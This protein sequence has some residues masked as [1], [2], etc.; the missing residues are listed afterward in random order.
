MGFGP[1]GVVSGDQVNRFLVRAENQGMYAVVTP[2]LHAHRL[3]TLSSWSSPFE[4]VSLYITFH[5]FFVI[6]D[7]SVKGVECPEESV[8]RTNIGKN[9]FNLRLVQ[10]LSCLGGGETGKALRIDRLQ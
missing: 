3:S 6:V 2:G 8:G 9:F 10:I 5:L 1:G 4:S 7:R